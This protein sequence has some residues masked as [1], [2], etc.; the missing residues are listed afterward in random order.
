MRQTC[1]RLVILL[2]LLALTLWPASGQAQSHFPYTVGLMAGL[3]GSTESDP[4]TGF[5]NTSWQAQFAM[6]IDLNTQWGVRLG[7]L[8]LDADGDLFDGELGYLTLAGEYLFSERFYKSGVYLGLGLYDF[9]GARALE[10]DSSLGAVLGVTGD[11]ELT[12]R[13]SVLAELSVHYTDLDHSQFFLM[14]HVGVGYRF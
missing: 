14:G 4:D 6:K 3:G 13:F 12:A 2:G 8:D 1:P 11:F 7:Q 10:D 9:D 5:G